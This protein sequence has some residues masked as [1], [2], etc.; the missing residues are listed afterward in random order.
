MRSNMISQNY[1]ASSFQTH[2]RDLDLSSGGPV[3][4]WPR[5]WREFQPLFLRWHSQNHPVTLP[6]IVGIGLLAHSHKSVWL[7]VWIL[8]WRRRKKKRWPAISKNLTVFGATYGSWMTLTLWMLSL[9]TK[10]WTDTLLSK[11]RNASWSQ[12]GPKDL[13]PDPVKTPAADLPSKFTCISPFSPVP[14]Q[15][16]AL[17]AHYDSGSPPE[18]VRY[19][20]TVTQ[21]FQVQFLF[22]IHWLSS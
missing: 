16:D 8:L 5:N 9:P 3:T 1:T 6:R 19:Y 4:D 10:L 13:D 18:Y 17:G 21:K 15:E 12:E 7:L 2:H 14:E 11:E 22:C 20:V